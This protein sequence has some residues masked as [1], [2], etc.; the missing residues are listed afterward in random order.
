[1]INGCEK[2]ESL[3]FRTIYSVKY[4]YCTEGSSPQTR[5]RG[6]RGMIAMFISV[7]KKL[8]YCY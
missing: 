6:S 2:L 1:M 3:E 4:M 7:T 8:T 5:V